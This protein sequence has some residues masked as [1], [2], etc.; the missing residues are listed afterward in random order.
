LSHPAG[1]RQGRFLYRN[2]ANATS[3]LGVLPV[4]LLFLDD[5][6][7]YLLPLILFNNFMDDLDGVL[8]AKLDIQSRFGADLDN[9]CDGV[10]H[11][12]LA[13]TVGANFGGMV[14]IFS[15]VAAGAIIL[16]V[17]SRLDPD[18]ATA[19]GSPTNELMRHLLFTLLL[20][21]T[22]GF[23]PEPVLILVFSLHSVSLLV[24][25]RMSALLR[26]HA[27]SATAV[28]L[29]NVSLVAAWLAPAVALPVAIAFLATYLYSFS[30]GGIL[31]LRGSRGRST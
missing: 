4:V 28:G 25:Y 22:L 31:W 7:R 26:A 17:V 29:V 10:A 9:V 19:G 21:E 27:K 18:R 15:T 23:D 2:L 24:T 14:L 1:A 6:Y 20:A 16:R 12:A 3:I 11:V 30:A 5:G 13:L 8:A